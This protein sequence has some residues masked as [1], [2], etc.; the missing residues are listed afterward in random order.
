V[1]QQAFREAVW[2]NVRVESELEEKKDWLGGDDERAFV[3]FFFF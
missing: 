1:A 3:L 2:R